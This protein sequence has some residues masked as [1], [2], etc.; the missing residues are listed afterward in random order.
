MIT[1][2]TSTLGS[3]QHLTIL[4]V[5]RLVMTVATRPEMA[6]ISASLR[7]FES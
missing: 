1:A 4:W 2:S 3:S 7:S 6:A 5:V